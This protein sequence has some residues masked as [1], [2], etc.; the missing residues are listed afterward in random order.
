MRIS[1][2]LFLI[3][4]F[5]ISAGVFFSTIKYSSPE[6]HGTEKAEAN[7]YDY[8]GV[9]NVHSKKSNGRGSVQEIITA[10]G[11]AGLDFIVFNETNPL[12]QQQPF[13]IK[14]GQLSVLYGVELNFKN[15]RFLHFSTEKS[16]VFSSH[17]EIQIY[18]SNF[19]ETGGE[20]V[21][22][23]SHPEKP[24]Y[25]WGPEEAPDYMTGMEVLNLRE[26]WRKSWNLRRFSFLSAVMFYPFNPQLFFLDIYLE[27]ALSIKLWDKWNKNKPVIGYVGSDATSKLRVTKNFSLN[28]PSYKSIFQMA[29]NHIILREELAGFGD[30][31]QIVEALKNGNSYF[32]IDILGA[33]KGFSFWGLL[34]GGKRVIMGESVKL[35]DLQKLKVSL[36]ELEEDVKIELYHN[37]DLIEI[38]TEDFEFMPEQTGFYRVVV[39]KNPLFPL[40]R[41]Q[42]WIPWIF[43]NPIFVK[44]S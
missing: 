18:V 32:S 22:A 40:I 44:G 41:G 9:I 42:K 4:A 15:S 10:A 24:G 8:A 26:V 30:Q 33:P 35:D 25:E 7:F 39:R 36:P 3:G 17:S 1:L 2:V 27:E 19:L 20:G 16:P 37:G 5:Y 13:P 34:P 12:D 31:G 6:G 21:M 11:A 23:L 28:F 29:K 38:F 14:F 43:S